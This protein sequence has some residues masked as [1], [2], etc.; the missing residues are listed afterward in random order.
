MLRR[1]WPDDLHSIEATLRRF[2]RYAVVG[3]CSTSTY[4][5]VFAGLIEFAG[6]S[7][8]L[9]AGFAF[10]A[11]TVVSYLGNALWAFGSVV[12]GR[13]SVRFLTVV[14]LTFCVNI[15]I[16]VGME[17]LG[18]HYLIIF[19]VE[20]VVLTGLNFLGHAAWTFR[21]GRASAG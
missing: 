21:A 7:S 9:A 10:C 4:F 11:A 17:H 8:G 6:S 15:A 5:V 3:L 18:F 12:S 2:I 19:A 20:V 1:L 14:G 13:T 16:A